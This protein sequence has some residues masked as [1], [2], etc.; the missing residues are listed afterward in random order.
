MVFAALKTNFFPENQ[1]WEYDIS[2]QNAA[3]F[4]DMCIFRREPGKIS[5]KNAADE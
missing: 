4:G 3:L 1:W 5:G 2:F